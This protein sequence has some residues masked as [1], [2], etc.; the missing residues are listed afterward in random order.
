[1]PA[2]P[3]L[4][5]LHK[6]SRHLAAAWVLSHSS[7]VRRGRLSQATMH[8]F[9]HIA[10]ISLRDPWIVPLRSA[11]PPSQQALLLLSDSYRQLHSYFLRHMP[12][13]H[14]PAMHKADANAAMI[15]V[16]MK[17]AMLP[18]ACL[19][20][21]CGATLCQFAGAAA[22]GTCC[23]R[24]ARTEGLSARAWSAWHTEGTLPVIHKAL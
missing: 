3:P 17:D 7:F 12:L 24:E 4:C 20:C 10:A 2:S 13:S 16:W 23:A 5:H 14:P 6:R 11:A 22:G 9:S 1:M 15:T 21:R 8:L 19:C 18:Y